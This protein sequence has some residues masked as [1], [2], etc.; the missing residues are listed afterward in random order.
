METAG[1]APVKELADVFRAFTPGA[2]GVWT[3]VLMF[4]AWG[5][6]EWRETRKLSSDDR[7]A[8]RDGYA[9]Q[10]ELLMAENRALTRDVREVR[11]QYDQYRQLCLAE[12]DQLRQAMAALRD[13]L[14]ALK[15]ERAGYEAELARL[16]AIVGP[17]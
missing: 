17:V 3:G 1:V 12:N 13:E 11:E 4:A 14:A 9:R 15:R 6:R 16:R 2:Y 7:L 8:R 10:V 5:L